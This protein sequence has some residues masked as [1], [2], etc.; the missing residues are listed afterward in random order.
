MLCVF[1]FIILVVVSFVLVVFS[2][3][4]LVLYQSQVCDCVIIVCG[5]II[6]DGIGQV[7]VI[8]G[9]LVFD[10]F[11]KGVLQGL[12]VLLLFGL[13]LI[14]VDGFECGGYGMAD[15]GDEV[16]LI[17]DD[18]IGIIE[19]FKVIVNFDCGVM[20]V[21]KYQNSIGVMLILWQGK[22]ELI[23]VGDNG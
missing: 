12:C 21:I 6:E 5:L 14:G 16:I 11:S 22:F 2:W 23:F 15:V 7:C 20:L 3:I 18:V 8:F 17:L 13:I 1:I 9:V 4:V 10:L 19:V